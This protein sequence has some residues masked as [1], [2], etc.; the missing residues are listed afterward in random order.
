MDKRCLHRCLPVEMLA[1][2]AGYVD[3]CMVTTG[4]ASAWKLRRCMRQATTWRA[5]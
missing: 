4:A 1:Q 2:G 3:H 5:A